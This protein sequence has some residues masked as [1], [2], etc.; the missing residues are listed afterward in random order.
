MERV[1]SGVG[2]GSYD[3]IIM[4]YVSTLASRIFLLRDRGHDLL[5]ARPNGSSAASDSH[6][7]TSWMMTVDPCINSFRVL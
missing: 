5:C 1:D 3:L 4:R 7:C 2:H 6:G